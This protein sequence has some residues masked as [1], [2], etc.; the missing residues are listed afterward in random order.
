MVAGGEYWGAGDATSM[1]PL[2]IDDAGDAAGDNAIP[3][4]NPIIDDAGDD[5]MKTEF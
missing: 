4:E 3:G 5:D 2:M 1:T